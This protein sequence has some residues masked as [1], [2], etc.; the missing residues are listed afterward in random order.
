MGL[1]TISL[2]ERIASA[3]S[4]ALG[5]IV[6]DRG[7]TVIEVSEGVLDESGLAL[8]DLLGQS[9]IDMV[10]PDDLERAAAVLEEI[11][12]LPGDRPPAVYR[13][14]VGDGSYRQFAIRATNLGAEHG[15]AILLAFHE[16]TQL[17]LAQAFADDAVDTM[18]LLS[19]DISLDEGLNWI[20][21]VAERHVD[22]LQ[23]VITTFENAGPNRVFSR[24]PVCEELAAVN[25][26]AT[27]DSLPVHVE[28]AFNDFSQ[29][30]WR[31]SHKIASLDYI[32]PGRLTSILADRD[33]SIVGYVEALRS[34]AEAPD[35]SEWLVHGMITRMMTAALHRYEFDRQL[36]RA[37]DL[38]SLTGLL[39]R[40]KLFEV[41]AADEQLA[42]SLMYLIDLD[43]FSWVNNNLGHQAGDETLISIAHALVQVCPEQA[44]IARLGGDEFVVWIPAD[45]ASY[46]LEELG[47]DISK[48]MV[49][50]AGTGDQRVWVRGSIGMV[51]IVPGE[52]AADALN[53]ADVAM[54]ASK[55][56]GGDIATVG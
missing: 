26:A 41:L 17:I 47:G 25:R 34:T 8:E 11:Q 27:P 46:D 20:A 29:R 7:L 49:V 1:D 35:D 21:R 33:G 10:H 44:L 36:R 28:V 51:R 55:R 54:Y 5:A 6:V 43:R 12:H 37:A 31:I 24:H 19:E 16:P 4:A 48:A 23:I 18:R 38:D 40:R 53:R 30:A 15:E 50:P 3:A 52:A 56:S 9:A 2:D 14:K 39:N 13:L 32:Q 45:Q 22:G 42:G